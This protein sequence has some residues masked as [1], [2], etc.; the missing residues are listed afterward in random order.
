M[1]VS[2]DEDRC[3]GHG[4]CCAIC[5][6]VFELTELGYATVHAPEVPTEHQ[7]AVRA[8]ANQCPSLAISIDQ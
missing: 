3:A 8:A 6:E 2:V 4:V 5:P 7:A 1:K